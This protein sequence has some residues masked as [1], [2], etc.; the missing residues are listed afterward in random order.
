M[1]VFFY[2]YIHMYGKNF[3]NCFYT[4]IYG[5]EEAGI[6]AHFTQWKAKYALFPAPKL[7]SLLR[8]S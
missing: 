6:L 2:P 1:Q 3:R 5:L 8:K 7:T 4:G